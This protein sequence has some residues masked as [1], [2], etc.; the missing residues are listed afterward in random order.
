MT[1]QAEFFEANAVDGKLT[2]AQMV[3]FLQLPE[4]DIEFTDSNSGEPGAASGKAAATDNGSQVTETN[5]NK[6]AEPSPGDAVILAKD[7][8]HTIPYTKLVEAREGEK[9]WKAQAEAAQAQLAALQAASDQRAATGQAET[10]TDKNVATATA[11]IESGQVDPEIFG[12]FSEE[13]LAKGIQKLVAMGIERSI[14]SIRQEVAPLKETQAK[15]ARDEHYAAIYKAHPDADSVAESKELSD[16][17]DSKP[18]FARD[19][20]RAV[21]QKGTAAQVVELF[22]AFKTETTPKTGSPSPSARPSAADAAKAAIDAAKSK[23]PASLSEL[24]GGTAGPADELEAMRN[25]SGTDLL[26]RMHGK[27]PEQIEALVARLI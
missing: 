15:T 27:T 21:L 17:I 16:W 3:Q 22:T 19:G 26:S 4:G 5:E 9:H 24:P 11:A 1:T 18:S 20:Y 12:D 10:Q 23:V 14:A 2:D 6:G 25:M 8:V 7:G 13:A